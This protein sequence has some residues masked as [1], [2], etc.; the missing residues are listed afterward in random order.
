MIL[1]GAEGAVAGARTCLV[2]NTAMIA[3]EPDQLTHPCR[4][5]NDTPLPI[6]SRCKSKHKAARR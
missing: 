5:P 6:F 4:D 1:K 3:V 2:C